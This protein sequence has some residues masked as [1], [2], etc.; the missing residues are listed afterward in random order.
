[1]LVSALWNRRV[2]YRWDT[3]N[4]RSTG[5]LTE[6]EC[7]NESR[8]TL[9]R[10][11][12]TGYRGRALTGESIDVFVGADGGVG[13]VETVRQG[14]QEGYDLVLLRIRQAESTGRHVDV[15]QNLGLRPAGHPF[16]RSRRAVTG[17]DRECKRCKPVGVWH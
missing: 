11:I 5:K 12:L 14:L 10:C 15:V 3:A 1:M 7:R 13:R 2:G 6:N 16:H 4:I 8:I 17:R 9:V